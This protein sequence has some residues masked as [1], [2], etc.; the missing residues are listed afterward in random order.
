MRTGKAWQKITEEE[1]FALIGHRESS[2]LKESHNW[3][4]SIIIDEETGTLIEMG[5]E[6]IALPRE[7]MVQPIP[8]T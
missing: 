8:I 1:A 5:N 6:V 2:D 4:R 3:A 7:T